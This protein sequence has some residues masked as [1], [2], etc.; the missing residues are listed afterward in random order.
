MFVVQKKSREVIHRHVSNKEIKVLPAPGG[1]KEVAIDESSRQQ[2]SLTPGGAKE[3]A[4]DESSR[5]QSSL[6]DD[7]AIAIA[8]LAAEIEEMGK[9]P[10]DVEWAIFDGNVYILQSR[11]ITALPSITQ[12]TQMAT[13]ARYYPAALPRYRGAILAP[14]SSMLFALRELLWASWTHSRHIAGYTT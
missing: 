14:L 3:V 2:S 5:Q 13:S 7:Q 9:H 4:I 1:A 6:T 12:P 11:P 8:R 10:V